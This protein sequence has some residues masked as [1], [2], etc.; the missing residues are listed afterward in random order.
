MSVVPFS[1]PQPPE[2]TVQAGS[3]AAAQQHSTGQRG[4]LGR[5]LAI[6]LPSLVIL[7]AVIWAFYAVQKKSAQALLKAAEREA[8]QISVQASVTESAN[9]RSDLLYLSDQY[10]L[11]DDASRS[12][13]DVHAALAARFS[14]FAMRKQLYGRLRLLDPQGREVVR[15]DWNAGTPL[16][17]ARERLQDQSRR[18]YFIAALALQ[19]GEIHVSRFGGDI[20]PGPRGNR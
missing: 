5:F 14:A 10:T 6:W 18:D 3:T 7:A 16:G 13:A 9:V 4:L 2:S 11:L 12:V 17:V 19:R 15:V 20:A 8:I 1:R